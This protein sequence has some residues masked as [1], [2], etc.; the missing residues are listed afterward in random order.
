MSLEDLASCG[1]KLLI[2]PAAGLAAPVVP[3]EARSG[4]TSLA[5]T[6]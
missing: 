5:I 1:F 2:D 4:G 3:T 6:K